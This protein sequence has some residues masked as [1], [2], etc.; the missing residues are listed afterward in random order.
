MSVAFVIRVLRA[1]KAIW[2]VSQQSISRALPIAVIV[3]VGL[4]V[5]LIQVS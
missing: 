5:K 3:T 1:S 2:Q 4:K